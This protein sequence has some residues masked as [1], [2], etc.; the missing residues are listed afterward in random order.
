[1]LFRSDNRIFW[2]WLCLALGVGTAWFYLAG[3][4]PEPSASPPGSLEPVDESGDL[5]WRQTYFEEEVRPLLRYYGAQNEAAAELAQKRWHQIMTTHRQ[6]IPEFARDLT[7]WGTRWNILRRMPGDWWQED[8]RI[9]RY[10]QAKFTEYFFAEG[11]LEA[12]LYS[13]LLAYRGDLEA[14]QNTLLGAVRTN[15]EGDHHL[16]LEAIDLSHFTNSVREELLDYSLTAGRD[17]LQYGLATLLAGEMV[18]IAGTQMVIRLGAM[19]GAGAATSVAAGGGAAAGS[20]TA[21]G[22]AGIWG[23]PAGMAVGFGVGLVLG[24]TVDWYMTNRFEERLINELDAYFYRL[25]REVRRGR[26]GQPGLDAELQRLAAEL[27]IIQEKS[28]HRLFFA[29]TENRAP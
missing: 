18:A 25:E 6:A 7:S 15:F 28:L 12:A 3:P 23:G 16:L 19:I 11:E 29:G 2:I 10:V 22:A 17:S 26:P 8:E 20:A 24:V 9:A 1:M 4:D 21:G 27:T 13:V 5:L 14:N